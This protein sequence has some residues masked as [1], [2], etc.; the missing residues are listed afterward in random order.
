MKK[1]PLIKL[2]EWLGKNR[3]RLFFSSGKVVELTLS[4]VKDSRSAH[5]VDDGGGLDPGNGRDV[6]ASMLAE[7]KGRVL[8]E[9]RRGYVGSPVKV[10][11]HSR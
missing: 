2:V 1:I 6:A 3:V 7:K 5:I 10:T 11:T 9:G 4:W 8:C